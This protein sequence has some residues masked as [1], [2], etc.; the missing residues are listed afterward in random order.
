MANEEIARF[1]TRSRRFPKLIGRMT[2]GSRIPGGP[3]TMTQV[4]SG[5][6]VFLVAM[7]TRNLW[8]TDAMLL[9]LIITAA[10]TYAAIFVV[11]F[12]PLSR[13]NLVAAFMG[14]V[15]AI[16]RPVEGKYQGKV[17]KLRRPHQVHGTALVL[18]FGPSLVEQPTPA[19]QPAL[20]EATPAPQTSPALVST[21][22]AT[23]VRVPMSAVERLLLQAKSNTKENI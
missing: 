3:Y 22:T 18:S 14:A 11:G 12:L 5:G 17:P 10:I 21:S 19:P 20:E 23:A 4:L 15:S 2:D 7:V 8:T 1:Y 13:R 16:F 6:V 9:D